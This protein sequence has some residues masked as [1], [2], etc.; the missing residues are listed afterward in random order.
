MQI[1]L[2]Q[3]IRPKLGLCNGCRCKLHL[4][5]SNPPVQ[6]S[7]QVL[8]QVKN[9]LCLGFK[10][11]LVLIRC[12]YPIR[13]C[14]AMTIN[15]SQGQSLRTVGLDLRIPVFAH[16]QLY[17]ALSRVT[18]SRRLTIFSNSEEWIIQNV[19]YPEALAGFQPYEMR[20]F[21]AL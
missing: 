20:R 1:M 14:F 12:Q 19:V 16:G 9:I 10:Y 6:K 4:S 18:G 11:S 8:S 7:W 15:K 3:N 21:Y 13:P 17:I 5:R 2:L